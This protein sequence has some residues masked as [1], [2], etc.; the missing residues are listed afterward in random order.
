M[1]ISRSGRR[2]CRGRGRVSRCLGMGL[3]AAMLGAC[4]GGVPLRESQ[5]EA[6]L[7]ARTAS[8]VPGQ[9][10]R[11]AVRQLLGEPWLASEYW[12][13]DLFR[14][15][16]QDMEAL[17][18]FAPVP[19]PVGVFSD[20]VRGYVLVNYKAN[21]TV[22]AFDRGVTYGE[23]LSWRR[24]LQGD[25]SILLMA[26]E[27]RF[28][29]ETGAHTPSVFISAQRRDEYLST[30]QPGDQ[31]SALVGCLQDNCSNALVL[32]GGEARP[33]PGALLRIRRP[34]AGGIEVLTQTWLAPLTL[35]PGQHRMEIPPNP[36]TTLEA[37]TEFSCAAG[38][39][40]YAAIEIESS[41]KSQAWRHWKTQVHGSI[42]VSAQMPKEF[43]EQPMLI[44]R[45]DRWLVP[46]EPS[47]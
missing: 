26:G 36:H 39:L 42:N 25:D 35:Q 46:A 20:D 2:V 1:Q 5:I 4:A 16:G 32:D 31:C 47:H 14:M 11:A 23:N 6:S 10:D 38:E 29:V 41:D 28:A 33:L 12:R 27:D 13:F 8:I 40:V 22:G 17:V 34:D 45:D 18:I 37:S 9:T 3:A 7:P 44:W 43:R 24:P 15:T 30:L 19:V 21:G